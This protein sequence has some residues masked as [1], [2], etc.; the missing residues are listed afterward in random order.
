MY[1]A[2]TEGF[3]PYTYVTLPSHELKGATTISINS[4]STVLNDTEISKWLNAT[5]YVSRF[6]GCGTCMMG[7]WYAGDPFADELHKLC[8]Y[9]VHSQISFRGSTTIHLG[10]L[11]APVEIKKSVTIAGLNQLKGLS[12]G[13]PRLVLPAEADGTNLVGNLTLANPGA[14]AIKFGDLAFNAS[15]AGI[16]IGNLSISNVV[17]AQGNNTV[18]F[19]GQILLD[20][21]VNNLNTILGSA[22]GGSNGTV[23]MEISGGTCKVNGQHITYIENVLSSSVMYASVPLEE[24]IQTGL[25]SI[26]GTNSSTSLMKRI[27]SFL[28]AEEADTV[29]SRLDDGGAGAALPGSRGLA[30][31][32]SSDV[33][34]AARIYQRIASSG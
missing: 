16:F 34:T 6:S 22:T 21:V 32:G 10:A 12:L 31:D 26:M 29:P 27:N 8:S 11:S 17:L 14:V 18:P 25:S 28:D 7:R 20:A 30:W 33:A 24:L 1:N 15:V 23:K 9:G 2:F 5:L 4:T 3:Y 19:K 13:T